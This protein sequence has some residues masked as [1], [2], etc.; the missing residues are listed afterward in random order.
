LHSQ[1]HHPE[2]DGAF[3]VIPVKMT[4]RILSALTSTSPVMTSG[5][6][7][8]PE[9][10]KVR[11]KFVRISNG[12]IVGPSLTLGCNGGFQWIGVP[13]AMASTLNQVFTHM[14]SRMATDTFFEAISLSEIG[15]NRVYPSGVPRMWPLNWTWSYNKLITSSLTSKISSLD[16][17]LGTPD[18]VCSI[19]VWCLL[20]SWICLGGLV[21]GSVPVEHSLSSWVKDIM[22]MGEASWEWE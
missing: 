6:K 21:D 12:N 4:P 14:S 18:L 9:H 10:N 7:I 2:L 1:C 5:M 15:S 19:D 8:W 13:S 3:S 22:G 11:V 16:S 17:Y 20:L